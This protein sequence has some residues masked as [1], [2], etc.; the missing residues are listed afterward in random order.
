LVQEWS[1]NKL[2]YSLIATLT[3]LLLYLLTPET[4]AFLM[5]PVW[6]LIGYFLSK[7]MDY[8]SIPALLIAAL[9][10]SLS[11]HMEAS[12]LALGALAYIVRRW[13]QKS[14]R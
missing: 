8:S 12:S 6:F 10:Y 13:R 5:L 9:L 1:G 4:W 2:L 11:A 14:S 3:I 7:T